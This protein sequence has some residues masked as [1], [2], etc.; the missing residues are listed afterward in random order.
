MLWLSCLML[1]GSPSMAADGLT[2]S[3][4]RNELALGET[5]QLTISSKLDASLGISLFNLNT[6]DIDSPEVSVLEEDF[7]ILD[8]QQNYRVQFENNVNNSLVAWTYTLSP[9]RAGDITIP[10][11]SLEDESTDP[12]E[13]KVSDAPKNPADSDLMVEMT[14]DKESAYVGEQMLLTVKLLYSNELV[15]GQLAHPNVKGALFRQLEKQKEYNQTRAGKRFEVVERQ[16]AVFAED[17]GELT[18]PAVKFSGRFVNRRFGRGNYETVTS[19]PVS[20]DIKDPPARFSGS[21]WLPAMGF[22]VSESYEPDTAK[23][24]VGESVTRTITLQGLGLESATLPPIDVDTPDG[25][26]LYPGQSET[27]EEVHA[28]G[29]TGVRTQE[30]A[31]IATRPGRFVLPEIRIP[32]WDVVNDE[33]RVAILPE[34][35]LEVSGSGSGEAALA[36][37]PISDSAE[38]DAERQTVTAPDSATPGEATAAGEYSRFWPLLSLILAILCLGLGWLAWHYRQRAL[39]A[40]HEKAPGTREGLSVQQQWAR[41]ERPAFEAMTPCSFASVYSSWLQKQTSRS[42]VA[43]SEQVLGKIKAELATLQQHC[44]GSP[45]GSADSRAAELQVRIINFTG[46]WLSKSADDAQPASLAESLYPGE[47]APQR[48]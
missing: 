3:V 41:R 17:S 11:L 38:S 23:L 8:R 35:V 6:L 4:D 28:A 27:S 2:A 37:P 33:Q 48:D 5:V 44:F 7:E 47:R 42:N 25:V 36:P 30:Y 16:Y 46:E 40:P 18:I 14:I 22:S 32:W 31:L 26:R 45:T 29:I 39:Q 1:I 19:P 13:L 12:I 10:A 43:R 34:R 21:T 9:K 15:D 20:V 24:Q